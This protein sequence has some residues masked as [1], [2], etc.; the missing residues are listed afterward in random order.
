MTLAYACIA[1]HGSET[2]PRLAS[3]SAVRKFQ[4]TNRGLQQL[5]K[6]VRKAR[7]DIIVIASPHNLKLWG[8]IAVVT[9]ENSTG[10][11]QASPRNK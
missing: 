3:K 9:A 7:P 2:I 10:L 5:A 1:P 4:K 11:L 6:E 8:K